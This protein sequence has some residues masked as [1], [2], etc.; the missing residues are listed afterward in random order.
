MASRA[1]ITRLEQRIGD[2]ARASEVCRVVELIGWGDETADQVIAR[3]RSCR[4][5]LAIIP[6]HLM[7]FAFFRWLTCDEAIGRGWEAGPDGRHLADWQRGN[8]NGHKSPD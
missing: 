8:A 3:H 2:L 6:R 5:E 1:Q 7:R 4:P